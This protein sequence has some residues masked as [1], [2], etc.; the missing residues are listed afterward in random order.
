MAQDQ[1]ADLATAIKPSPSHE[2]RGDEEKDLCL[3]PPFSIQYV[4]FLSF[5]LMIY[6]FDDKKERKTDGIQGVEVKRQNKLHV[7]QQK[8]LYFQDIHYPI[9]G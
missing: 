9:L 1:R 8:V 6:V 5:Y 3:C 4:L 2:N 7:H